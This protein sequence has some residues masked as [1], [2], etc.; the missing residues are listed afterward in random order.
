MHVK[1]V[2]DM[3]MIWYERDSWA[4]R[5]ESISSLA[6]QAY[7]LGLFSVTTAKIALALTDTASL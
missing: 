1:V 5:A 3:I 4:S 2:C 6:Q 7:T